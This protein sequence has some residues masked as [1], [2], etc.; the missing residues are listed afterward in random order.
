MNEKSSLAK[1]VL[2][3]LLPVIILVIAYQ[4]LQRFNRMEPEVRQQEKQVTQELLVSPVVPH[5]KV[6]LLETD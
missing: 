3:Y 5:D 1:N 6:L 2:G 4:G